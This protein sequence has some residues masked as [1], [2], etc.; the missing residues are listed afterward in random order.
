MNPE[1]LKAEAR[2]VAHLRAELLTHYLD[3]RTDDVALTDTL[4]GL[5]DFSEMVAA[6]IQSALDDAT[7]QVGIKARL[8]EIKARL[9]RY[10]AREERKRALAQEL[11][12]LAGVRKLERPEFTVSFRASPAKVI[13]LN[14][15]EIPDD[16]MRVTVEPN[17]SKI[18]DL[19][20]TGE[21][22][23]GATLSNQPDCISIRTK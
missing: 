16:L 10:E 2:K 18:R 11:M 7:M 22:V 15:A 19:L 20:K 13:I 1:T 6:V 14:E 21:D 23:P 5:T 17:K 4:D 12:V 8:D 3:L 9:S